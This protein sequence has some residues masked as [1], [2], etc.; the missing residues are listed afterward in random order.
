MKKA[1]L[2]LVKAS[3]SLLAMLTLAGMFLLALVYPKYKK[4]LSAEIAGAVERGSDV[5]A[6]TDDEPMD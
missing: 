3:V 6:G 2:W 4:K 5:A 1:M